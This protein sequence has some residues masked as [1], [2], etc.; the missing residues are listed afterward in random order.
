MR[1][2]LSWFNSLFVNN[3]ETENEK[4][5]FLFSIIIHVENS[6]KVFKYGKYY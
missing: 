6:N 3:Q 5:C 4:M 2:N 1:E